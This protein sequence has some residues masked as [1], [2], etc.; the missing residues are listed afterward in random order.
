MPPLHP[1]I[2][3]FPIAL[4][5][6][7]VL[8]DGITMFTRKD[9]FDVATR[10]LMVF[11]WLGAGAAIL[12]GEWLKASRGTFLPHGLLHTHQFLAISFGV[13][14]TLLTALRVRR[15]WRPTGG[16]M[17]LA[18]L[19]VVLLVF[20]GHTGGEMAWPTL[21]TA[22]VPSPSA[23]AVGPSTAATGGVAKTT[24]SA[25]AP[26]TK[27]TTSVN[28]KP[29]GTTSSTGTHTP[30]TVSKSSSTKTSTTK[31]TTTTH[32]GS[33]GSTTGS[34]T[35]SSGS[36]TSTNTVNQVLYSEGAR[37]FVNDCQACHSL[38]TSQQYFGQLSQAQ[39]QQ[40]V[41]SMQYRS[42]GAISN[43]AAS[44]I[45]YYFVHQK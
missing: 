12:T 24:K 45:V 5:V 3:H 2:V 42:G 31:T 17:T 9:S 26:S 8:F 37:Y 40:I 23:V 29:A 16:Y 4:F 43:T 14:I 13:W 32:S 33:S 34:T 38:G 19:G 10:W 21:P 1:L 11:S 28:T 30:A 15:R 35:K 6:V 22:A 39:W 44:A 41:A 20:V 7:A 18:T 27:K 36:S 25:T